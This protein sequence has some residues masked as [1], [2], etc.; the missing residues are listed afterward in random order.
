MSVGTSWGG[1]PGEL[2]APVPAQALLPDA[3]ERWLRA[4]DVSAPADLVWRWLCQ[5]RVAP[6]SYDK[7]DNLG[8]RSPQ[9]LTPGLDELERGQHVMTLF[10]VE[11]WERGG[12]LTVRTRPRLIPEMAV[13]YVVEPGAWAAATSR[14][15]MHL[16]VRLPS[17]ARNPVGRAGLAALR[18]GDLVMARRQLLNL[19]ALAER[20]AQRRPVR[21]LSDRPTWPNSIS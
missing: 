18:V 2:E 5:M 7:L 4:V 21:P 17:A 20:D 11:T 10:T 6:Y 14:L 1:R 16:L 15:S 12:H 3:Q 9:E 8:R 19:A 13:S